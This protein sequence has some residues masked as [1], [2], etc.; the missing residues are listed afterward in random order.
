MVVR[1]KILPKYLHA[2][3]CTHCSL[4]PA[5]EKLFY[6]V[7]GE[8]PTTARIVLVG[9]GP[10]RVETVLMRPFV[11]ESGKLL[12]ATLTDVGLQ[13]AECYITNAVMCRHDNNETP[14]Q[15][16]V[17]ACRDRLLAEL[18]AC[19][20]R[21]VLVLMGAT[22]I[23]AVTG[24]Q[25][26][27]SDV[28]GRVEWHPEWNAFILYTWHPAF[29]LR[30][31]DHF[32]EF[33]YTLQ[34]AKDLL[35]RPKRTLVAAQPVT[36]KVW[37]SILP[38]CDRLHWIHDHVTGAISCDIETGGEK[39]EDALEWQRG[40]VKQIG[41]CFDGRHADIFP[42][43]IVQD[44]TF[45]SSLRVLFRSP[46]LRFV[47]HN[48][49]FDVQ[50]LTLLLGEQPPIHED[51]MLLHYLLDER[52]GGS[53]SDGGGSHRLKQLAYKYCGA[54]VWDE[55]VKQ[56][57]DFTNPRYHAHDLAYTY[58]L[59]E[60]LL[61]E[62]AREKPSV[63]GYPQPLHA[64]RSIV[65]PA[66][67][68]IADIEMRGFPIDM[69][70]MRA[71]DRRMAGYQE[72]REGV[73]VHVDG[74]L[75][76]LEKRCQQLANITIPREGKKQR[77]AYEVMKEKGKKGQ[78]YTVVETKYRWGEREIIAEPLN[79]R[80]T[81]QLRLFLYEHLGLPPLYAKG[82]VTGE[83]TT[84]SEALKEMQDKHPFI[85]E[86]LA[87][88]AMHKIH[89]TY[90]SGINRRLGED[91]LV[92]SHFNLHTTVTG[93]PSSVG[94]NLQNIPRIV[95]SPFIARPG[96]VLLEADYSNQ[97]VRVGA[98]LSGDKKLQA[99][100]QVADF[101]WEVTKAVFRSVVEALEAAR[102][103]LAALEILLQTI[104][105]FSAIALKHA[106]TPFDVQ[107][108][109]VK[110]REEIRK[111]AKA[112][113]FGVMYGEGGIGL[114]HTLYVK[115]GIEISIEQGARYISDWLHTYPDFAAWSA[116]MR[117]EVEHVGFVDTPTGRRRRFH[118]LT[119]ETL[120]GSE[121]QAMNMPIQSLSS[122]MTMLSVVELHTWLTHQNIGQ[123]IL[124]VH[125][126]I[127]AEVLQGY[128][129]SVAQR[130]QAI[131]ENVMRNHIDATC[132]VPFPVDI[133][134]GTR[135]SNVVSLQEWQQKHF[136]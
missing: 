48:G 82:S 80:S 47:W 72:M 99:D 9:E 121:R 25:L 92:H 14:S 84:N 107:T 8:G 111:A 24:K 85:R 129:I 29:L 16:E 50:F 91:G 105:V 78:K 104:P 86:L 100:V 34:Q 28:Q 113:T 42:E 101:H 127:I 10:G 79:I 54:P 75:D 27:V 134:C 26:S 40:S 52:G 68:A 6:P 30:S 125:D 131:M 21:H 93:R 1:A 110:M 70:E 71:L 63:H 106:Q 41:F 135:W 120:A 55:G 90:V 17:L 117:Y 126:S 119:D 77:I 124:F 109:Y 13:R 130:M 7:G 45:R 32:P 46:N 87:Y 67:Q 62:H 108:L 73:E 114:A 116:L 15:S 11:G 81:K 128:E 136:A 44:A 89:S 2:C 60:V 103:S 98:Y 122:D 95:K 20:E 23:R 33:R 49:K 96:Y 35:E 12:T 36:W 76:V 43:A 64:Y 57:G 74:E 18:Q 83:P 66:I 112:I 38:A 56:S 69:E 37:G 61:R 5:T 94:P 65:L 4:Y 123:V 19:T 133:K 31:P 3:H 132:T 58:R 39:R 118:L 88:R 51:T 22:A 97:E 102:G 53:G 115:S 59:Y